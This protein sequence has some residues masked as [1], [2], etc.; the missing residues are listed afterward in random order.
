MD[1]VNIWKF[2]RHF[3]CNSKNLLYVCTTTKDSEFYLGRTKDAKNRMSKHISDV[4]LPG[5][6]FCKESVEHIRK[7]C[8]IEPFFI[9]IPFYHVED[10]H[11]RDFMEKRFIRRFNPTLNG[12]NTV[13]YVV[14]VMLNFRTLLEPWRKSLM[15]VLDLYWGNVVVN[16]GVVTVVLNVPR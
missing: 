9:F 4:R 6:S 7:T 10:E 8:T 16:R 14:W 2:T 13:W 11:L 1:H 5:N 15:V 12:N 3:N